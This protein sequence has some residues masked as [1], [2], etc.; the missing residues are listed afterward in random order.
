M[1]TRNLWAMAVISVSFALFG[2]SCANENNVATDATLVT[3]AT[4]EAQVASLSDAV[5]DQAEVYA[6]T[7]ASNGYTGAMAVKEIT[8]ASKPTVTVD[9]KDTITYPKTVIIDYGT[10]TIVHGDTLKGKIVVTISAKL[11]KIG[12]LKTITMTDFYI[13]SNKVTGTKTITN[14]GLNAN[15]NPSTTE[16]ISETITRAD[17]STITK[18]S[19]HTRERISDNG[20]PK[21]FTDDEFSITGSATGTNA[22]GVAYTVEITKPLIRYNDYPYFVQGT[23]TTTTQNRTAVLDYGDGTKDNKAILIVKGVTKNIILKN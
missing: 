15:N 2:T 7:L 5:S 11:S 17:K 18:N 4:D 6:N 14:N 21:V 13:N 23:V 22:K 20:T 9:K 8:N 19:T 12:S 1:K 16:T 10:G 3:T